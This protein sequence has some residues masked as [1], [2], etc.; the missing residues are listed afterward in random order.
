[1]MGHMYNAD[2]NA[3]GIVVGKIFK[4]GERC[5]KAGMQGN[6]TGIHVHTGWAK[7]KFTGTGWYRTPSGNWSI[8]NPVHMWDAVYLRPGTQILKGSDAGYAYKDKWAYAT[9]P[10][11]MVDIAQK[12]IKT[13]DLAVNM[14][15]LPS[16]FYGT[17]G[18]LPKNSLIPITQIST[19]F[20]DGFQWVKVEYDGIIGYSAVVAS[21]QIVDI[22]TTEEKLAL[23]LKEALA[24]I[25]QQKQT[26][27]DLNK[28]VSEKDAE[29]QSYSQVAT[30]LYEKK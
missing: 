18:A 29:L 10:A 2:F 4:Q 12:G 14:R 7:G 28:Q 9:T 19:N 11:N 20:V 5:Y 3:M 8:N 30:V 21:V 6:A 23:A 26:I 17:V 22:L 15:E 16:T 27:D 13:A 25:A 24:V 1:M